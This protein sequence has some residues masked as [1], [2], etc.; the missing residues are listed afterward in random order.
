MNA[1]SPPLF[2]FTDTASNLESLVVQ[3]IART[4]PSFAWYSYIIKTF[5]RGRER[6]RT[7]PGKLERQQIPNQRSLYTSKSSF[8]VTFLTNV[9]FLLFLAF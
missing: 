8:L 9:G 6:K 3:D 1:I 2:I 5:P 4:R 7:C